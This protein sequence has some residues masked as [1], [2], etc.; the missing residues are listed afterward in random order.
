[1]PGLV[2]A[3][4]QSAAF[5]LAL[6]ASFAIAL[7]A[8]ST[9]IA[10]GIPEEL[11][12][13]YSS[14]CVQGGDIIDPVGVLFRG[15]QAS[16]QKAAF[17]VKR[18][19][20]WT[21]EGLGDQK[22]K[23]K[24]SAG[25]YGCRNV[26]VQP[27]SE[28]DYRIDPSALIPDPIPDPLDVIDVPDER[29]HVR[30]WFIPSS[31]N[32]N[33]RKTVGT[34]H[35]EDFI[36]WNHGS[37]NHC[38][39]KIKVEIKGITITAKGSHAVDKGGGESGLDSGF[40]QGRQELRR[41][42]ENT[43]HSVSSENW[44]NDTLIEQ[45]DE[46]MAG[47]NGNGIV[48][49]MDWVKAGYTERPLARRSSARLLGRLDTTEKSTEW[50][51]EY[52]PSSSEGA[53]TYSK[54]T[55]VK[56]VAEPTEVDVNQAITGLSPNSTY[57]ARMFV[58][59][60]EGE[61]EE[62]NEVKFETCG[63]ESSDED[64]NSR[65]PRAATPE[66]GGA[67]DT[68][69]R[70]VNGDLGHQSWSAE[71]NW[72][73]ETRPASIARGANP[74]AFYR[75]DGS[76]VVDVF[77]REV[78]GDLGHQWWTPD[79]GWQTE[80]Q[81]ASMASDPS[82]VARL[83]GT[84]DVFFR[85]SGD[86]L[87]HEWLVPGSGWSSETRSATLSSDPH[88]VAHENGEMDVF[89]RS[90]SGLG[91]DHWAS[92]GGWSHEVRSGSL[93]AE[94][95][96]IAGENGA[97]DVFYRTAKDEL[98]H[99]WFVPGTGWSREARS[100][101]LVSDPHV[102]RRP[103]G[104][105]DVFYRT[106]GD[107]LGHD[108]WVSGTG[109]S[110]ETRPG[111]LSADPHVVARS[112]G[113]VEV[114]YR[115]GK[116]IAHQWYVPGTGWSDETLRGPIASH[117]DPH[118]V[119]Q[120][121][122]RIDVLYETPTGQLARDWRFPG[123]GWSHEVR[124]MRHLSRPVAAYSFD[125]GTGTTVEDLSGHGHTATIEGAE[126]TPH[127]HYGSGMQF[128]AEA[129]SMLS[130]ADADDLD[131]TEEFT[132]EAW[133]R[134][135][136]EAEWQTLFAKEDSASPNYSYLLYARDHDARLAA[137][138]DDG[139]KE[140]ELTSEP[141]ALR[142]RAWA[143][144]AL[145]FD[146]ARAR[147]Y[148]D[149]ELVKACSAPE[150]PATDGELAIGGN[151][152]WGEYFDG[153]IDEVRIYDRVLSEVEVGADK[154]APL[155]TPQ[156]TPIAAYSFDDTDDAIAEDLTGSGHTATIEG[157]E[158][159]RGRY[160]SALEF[161]AAEEDVVKVP[162]SPDLD[163]S[164]EFT[165]EAWVRPSQLNNEVSPAIF[166]SAG[167]GE[168]SQSFAYR[169]Y[170]GGAESNHPMAAIKPDPE[171]TTY[172][173]SGDAL[174]EQ[175]WSHIAMTYD[176]SW[177][178]I[179]VD[180]EE[181]NSVPSESPAITSG[182]LEIGAASALG[183]FFDGRIDEVRIYNRALSEREIQSDKGAPI[184][185]PQQDPIAAYS[186]DE[187]KGAT[188]FDFIGEHDGTIEGAQWAR[189][190][191]GSA[192]KFDGGDCVSVS[193]T[194]DLQLT[195][196][197]EFT[198]EAWVRPAVG[199]E[200]ADPVL[201]M[202]DEGAAEGEEAFSYMLLAG[203]EESPKAWVRKGGEAG[204]QGIYGT[205]PL[206]QNAWS[207]VAVTYDG[208]KLRLY[209]DG[210]LVRTEPG[211]AVSPADGPLAIGCY[212]FK[213]RIDEVRIYDRALD[214]GEVATDRATP[215]ETP[216]T[217]PIAAYSF[218]KGEGTLAEDS[219]G[220]NDGTIEGATWTRG[221]FGSALKFDGGDCVSVSATPDLQLTESEEFTLEA[222]VRPAVGGEYAD[223]VLGMED[224]GAAEGEE[225]FSY[226]LLAGGEESPKAWVRKGGEAGFQGIYG[227]EP[228]PQNAWS[229]VAVTYDGAKLR[230]YVD[231][232][233]VRTESGQ[234]VSSASG[235][236]TIGCYW[237]KGRIDEVRIYDRALDE[238]EVATD[239][240]TPIETPRSGPIATWSFDKGEGTVAEDSAGS[241]DGTIEGAQWARG[242]F[243]SALKFDGGDCVSV[244]ATPDLQLTESEE[245]TLEAWVRP[246]VGGEYADPV[247]GMEDEGAAEGEEAFSYMLLA[248]GEESPK[249]WVRKGGEAGFQGI[250]GT[251]PLPQNA[252]SHVAVTYDGAKLR[253]YVDGELVRTESGQA[254]SSADG[255]LTIGCYW[256]KGRIDEVRIYD[257]ALD[258][259]EV[260]TD[261]ALVT[262][263][264]H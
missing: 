32:A 54:K 13:E 149:G 173:Q 260:A 94:P 179:Y 67:V 47:S 37:G 107:E 131:M 87:G 115:D 89:Y 69:Y 225:A 198:L 121:S 127:G 7:C 257:R 51:F 215:I 56:S 41:S 245:F 140:H 146:G 213:G 33:E 236:L 235:P 238:G 151:S 17:E 184:Q 98:G 101:S 76:G 71:G 170:E 203:G 125:E 91:R 84:I 169:L 58:R 82:V 21:D 191:F 34:P 246:A 232:E 128:S 263:A 83:D 105:I 30:L 253:L 57:Y 36:P 195:E 90:G 73:T 154:D 52:G 192:L 165:L 250:Y 46:D 190:K 35:H 72:S 18:A 194:P 68:F 230:L 231:G 122:G 112:D 261:R 229:H 254:V 197:E 99:D 142:Q 144:V 3:P 93:V 136:S 134:P 133:V 16:A 222:W 153:R 137:H 241:H 78:G 92:K 29:F 61:I 60:A 233:L 176:G 226:M 81:V 53:G 224:E 63:G 196:S 150:L 141:A 45:C 129:E 108:W 55:S 259:G 247:L 158:W 50:W 214:E 9:V 96:P 114:F 110:T 251:E 117:T 109:W 85:T 216:R 228:L 95:R 163:F 39:G 139:E 249:A 200:Y 157:P 205:E 80:T 43:A 207:H 172:V 103:N 210:E 27:A 1:M 74:R 206:P 49:G 244:S 227:T 77:Y 97:V 26:A 211:Q 23:V 145:T 188:A 75:A 111:H 2:A 148:I 147:L 255:P 65:G 102:V 48:V 15:S 19:A 59:D 123:Y 218:D 64:D 180:G 189:G 113:S 240:A 209:V 187:G 100:E 126:W 152:V 12:G 155:Q 161:D 159:V 162:D 175:A 252:W 156:K 256:F 168:G 239:K 86:E 243:G 167:E 171:T 199:G 62:G 264:V 124:D 104:T 14:E 178:R 177:I 219:A 182:D 28:P 118:I 248:G 130:I 10:L 221:K 44:G 143:H 24:L 119:T 31:K 217:G 135:E 4:K 38:K 20:G 258:E 204:F 193:A 202:E 201:G 212:W 262:S 132:L 164:E 8:P 242:K 186:F 166:K 220:A 40:D 120:S 22:L 66:C 138:F 5:L 106:S 237:F 223:P 11:S 181:V 79:S 70:D 42:M 6:V 208:A 183:H 88:A 234:A 160:G 25:K 185:T 116:Q 174:P